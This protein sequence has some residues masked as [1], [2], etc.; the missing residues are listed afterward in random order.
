MHYTDSGV[1]IDAGN[2]AVARIKGAVRKTHSKNVLADL[3]TFSGMFD[4]SE[5]KN[6]K[7][8]VLVQSID[9][10][11]TKV[12]IAVMAGKYFNLGQ[13]IVNHSC[14][15]ILC[16]GAKPLTFLDYLAFHKT[17]PAIVEEIV[18]G[19]A[20]ACTEAGVSLIGGETAEMRNVYQ[21]GEFDIA[22]CITGMMERD[23]VITGASIK[24][25]DVLLGL[26]SS[27]LHTNGYS[28]V[29]K[30]FFEMN[31]FALDHR[32]DELDCTLGEELLKPHKNYAPI[33]LPLLDKLNSASVRATEQPAS[34]SLGGR[35]VPRQSAAIKG[36]AHITG[37]GFIENIPRILPQGLGAVITKGSWSVLSIFNLIQKLGNID[38]QEM[39]RVFNM[40]I[41]LVLVVNKEQGSVI[42]NAIE[43]S[44]EKIYEIGKIIDRKSSPV[45]IY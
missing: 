38:E 3:G 5:L 27:G 40:G 18:S 2:K 8:P 1:D 7:N 39:Y 30:I 6:Y 34:P 35:G 36:I 19:M 22:G 17:S 25:G 13:D 16:Q 28:L 37:G 4:V 33:V 31:N 9:G 44:G 20:Q 43:K 10:V 29:R 45:I 15:D 23:S 26:P 21:E 14:N 32:F 42:K 24:E 12:K 41:G 11:G